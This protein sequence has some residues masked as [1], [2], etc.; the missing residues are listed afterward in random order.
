[1]EPK[2]EGDLL[3]VL[4]KDTPLSSLERTIENQDNNHWHLQLFETDRHAVQTVQELHFGYMDL[5][6]ILQGGP[7]AGILRFEILTQ[8]EGYLLV[9]QP[10]P[11]WN[12]MPAKCGYLY[13]YLEVKVSGESLAYKLKRNSFHLLSW[14]VCCF[15]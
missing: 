12:T 14:I 7:R 10:P 4:S 9:C 1:M 3:T 13:D 8:N 15:L 5:K 2:I 11:L 6:Y